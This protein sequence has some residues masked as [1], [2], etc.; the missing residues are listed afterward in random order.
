MSKT[1]LRFPEG[2]IEDGRFGTAR[3]REVGY[4]A[5]QIERNTGNP[6]A[7]EPDEFDGVTLHE[8]P[9]LSS[10]SFVV[11]GQPVAKG[12]PRAG[13][14]DEGIRM[15]TPAKTKA[16]ERKIRTAARVAMHGRIPF[17]RPVSLKVAIYL[18]IP[19]SWPKI[20]QTKAR[21]GVICATNKPDADNVLKAIKD[22]MNEI[23]YEDDSQVVDIAVTKKYA[24]E[25]R[26]EVEVKELSG[27]AA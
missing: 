13:M 6:P 19:L 7:S 25:P 20:R 18:E 11:D 9:V 15:H 17:G 16:Y 4:A 14:T 1:S 22:G 3:V 27:E 2:A 5:R 8:P 26:V 12:R 10:V 21:I 24:M 23:V